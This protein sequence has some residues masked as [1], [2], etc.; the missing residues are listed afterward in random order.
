VEEVD[1]SF[2]KRNTV[3]QIL[4]ELTKWIAIP[5]LLFAS[6]FSY[7]AMKYEPW[8]TGAVILGAM[9]FI[10]WAV[11]ARQYLWAVGLGAVIVAFSPLFLVIKIF[12]VM[13][14]TCMATLAAVVSG[15]RAQPLPV[16]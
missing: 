14:L 1:W 15:F 5:I 4:R 8:L 6:M 10:G 12:L 2:E 11:R 9:I 16:V 13:G 7:F 3:F